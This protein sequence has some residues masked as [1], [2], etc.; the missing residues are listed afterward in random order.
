MGLFES[1]GAGLSA[2]QEQDEQRNA[3][4]RQLLTQLVSQNP[5]L[6]ETPEI[7]A[8]LS[9]AFPDEQ[10]GGVAGAFGMVNEAR[11]GEEE[12]VAG[13]ARGVKEQALIDEI[14]GTGAGAGYD[15][16]TTGGLAGAGADLSAGVRGTAA[17]A[18]A[19][20]LS[21]GLTDHE[22]ALELARIRSQGQLGSGNAIAGAIGGVGQGLLAALKTADTPTEQPG[23][24]PGAEAA[25]RA[26]LDLVQSQLEPRYLGLAQMIHL[27]RSLGESSPGVSSLWREFNS[28]IEQ[29]ERDYGTDWENAKGYV[30][31]NEARDPGLLMSTLGSHPEANT[32]KGRM[33]DQARVYLQ[34]KANER[35]VSQPNES[36][37]DVVN[38]AAVAAGQPAPF[39]PGDTGQDV[40]YPGQGEI[41]Y[42]QPEVTFEDLP[43]LYQQMFMQGEDVS[44]L[45]SRYA[46]ILQAHGFDYEAAKQDMLDLTQGFIDQGYLQP[47]YGEGQ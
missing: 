14:F 7:Q 30:G 27:N 20:E 6:A 3:I 5:A 47:M 31:A 43:P 38:R 21:D 36:A 25:A 4:T 15:V 12:R 45:N 26:D 35:I 22:R 10:F 18:R 28:N 46:T 40:L 17:A 41:I 2:I 32:I 9:D 19:N 39:P 11:L 42:T 13:V 8:A 33:D 16:D 1:F 37:F 34:D 24:A 23:L 44:G 29:F